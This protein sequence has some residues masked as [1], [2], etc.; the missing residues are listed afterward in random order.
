M[1]KIFLVIFTIIFSMA[2]LL[3]CSSGSGETFDAGNVNGTVP[4]GWKAFP[5]AD[6]FDDYEGDYDPNSFV[7]VKGG[8]EE[9][10]MFTK[11]AIT[12]MYYGE[13]RTMLDPS[14]TKEFYDGPQDIDEL[15]LDN[16]TWNGFT[17]ESL[18]YDM[19]LLWVEDGDHK[20]QVSLFMNPGDGEISL[21]DED[22][23]EIVESIAV[24][25]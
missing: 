1:K 20:F 3:G 9:W 7:L 25:K 17:G 8:E 15:A 11:P 16:Y 24:S 12:I 10:D 6:T 2:V 13:E 5:V 23:L 21:T 14:F 22:V 4:S 19:A 18:G